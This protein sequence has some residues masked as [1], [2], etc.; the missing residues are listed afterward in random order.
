MSVRSRVLVVAAVAMAIGG[1]YVWW[2]DAESRNER[3]VLYGNVDVREVELAFRQPG[4][5]ARMAVEEGDGVKSGD[6]VAELDAGPYRDALAAADAE[7]AA[8]QAELT[9]LERGNRP[10]EIRRAQEAVRQAASVLSKA[11]ADYARQQNL[12][13]TG[14]ASQKTLEAARTAQADAAAALAVAEQTLSLQR[15]GARTEDIEAARARLAATQ[16]RRA[17]AHTA[18]DDTRLV[19]PADATVLSRVREPGS[20]VG[21][22]DAVY[23]LSLRDPV[24]VRAYVTE[25]DLGRVVPGARVTITTDSSD[26]RYE[27]QVGFVSPRAE[28]TP[29]TVETTELRTDLVYRLRIIVG[30]SD[31]GLR[32]GMPVTVTVESAPLDGE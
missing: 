20:M 15:E 30:D 7:V 3:L 31:D 11:D 4:R 12:A 26:K 24:Y 22:R 17:Q 32:Q 8:A 19:S 27:G 6:V 10:Q 2:I 23:T 9:K 18:L 25:P 29:K 28:F 1:A 5:L 14:A 21:S 16:A 13:A